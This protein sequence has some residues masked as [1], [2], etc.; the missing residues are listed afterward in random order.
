M[1]WDHGSIEVNGIGLHYLVA[2][3]GPPVLLL[4]GLG[5]SSVVW[6]ENIV[7]LSQHFQV[8]ALDLPGHGDSEKPR[9]ID[10]SPWAAPRL[11]QEFLGA[12]G[13]QRASLVGNSAGGLLAVTFARSF[14]EWLE[15]LVLVDTAGL[16][17][18]LPWFLRFASL[19]L[20]G[21]LL[22]RPNVRNTQ[23][24]LRSVL[25]NP[26]S[27]SDGLV[28][29]LMRVRNLPGAKQAVLQSLRKGVNLL[30]LRRHYLM[31]EG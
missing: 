22:E 11:I 23:N 14:P 10:Y 15:R 1:Q 26:R 19:P 7:P 12:L 24:L 3:E 5:A 25:Y 2:G 31:L 4:H 21:E 6:W 27:V 13:I 18:E 30:G 16:G 29:E 8:Y 17:R 28:T 20:L 9:H